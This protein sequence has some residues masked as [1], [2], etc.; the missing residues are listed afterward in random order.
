MQPYLPLKIPFSRDELLSP[1]FTPDRQ[2][3]NY[4]TQI[5]RFSSNR[6]HEMAI[7]GLHELKNQ[8]EYREITD[9]ISEPLAQWFHDNQLW[10]Q[11]EDQG[12][13][14]VFYAEASGR[15]GPIHCDW[16]SVPNGPRSH[17][18]MNWTLG[19][20]ENHP[21]SWYE[22]KNPQVD[23]TGF[24]VEAERMGG[25]SRIPMFA[26]DKVNKIASYTITEP[27]LV[28]TDIPHN[29]QN[30]STSDRWCFSLRGRPASSWA[31][32]VSWFEKFK[33]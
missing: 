19:A 3:V 2:G 7:P 9:I 31:E 27:T 32:A 4:Y 21:M 15:P 33:A 22:P 28:R 26:P 20:T 5:Y 30:H 1:K 29:A 25:W 8:T 18:A 10:G 23:E 16:G 14:F 12:S 24:P 17:W 6:Q 11:G 13:L